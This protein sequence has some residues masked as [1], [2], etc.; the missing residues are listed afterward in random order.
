MRENRER[1]E[2]PSSN[3]RAFW[4][5][6]ETAVERLEQA[7]LRSDEVHLNEI[8]VDFD[9]AIRQRL[10]IELIKLDQ[11]KRWANQ[12]KR[13]VEDYL[14]QCP[15]LKR[16][17]DAIA[18]LL[19]S[20]CE[21]RT[22]NQDPP[23]IEE[24]ESRFPEIARQTDINSWMDQCYDLSDESPGIAIPK[25]LLASIT[26]RQSVESSRGSEQAL[27]RR[28]KLGRY[29]VLSVLGR[30]GM[31]IVYLAVDNELDRKVAIKLLHPWI[32]DP[33]KDQPLLKRDA[34]TAA[35]L[36]HP[37]ILP[38]FD[39][40][41]SDD[42]THF[43]VMEYVDGG[44]LQD[45]AKNH[46]LSFDAIAEIVAQVA[47]ALE[48]VHQA[49]F[50]H[51]DIKPAN[52]LIGVDGRARITDFGL[53]V[54]QAEVGSQEFSGTI[55]Y[56]APEQFGDK[57]QAID[58]RTDI[59][60]LGVVLFELLTGRRPFEAESLDHL[61]DAIQQASPQSPARFDHGV[62]NELNRICLKCLKKDPDERYARAHEM[63]ADLRSWSQQPTQWRKRAAAT[64]ALVVL[65]VGT[66]FAYAFFSTDSVCPW[67][68]RDCKLVLC[69]DSGA[70]VD[71][72][73]AKST[74]DEIIPQLNDKYGKTGELLQL[75]IDL[76][77][78][79][80]NHDSKWLG[81]EVPV[82]INYD[83]PKQEPNPDAG[84]FFNRYN[85]LI[86]PNNDSISFSLRLR[87]A[88]S[89]DGHF[90]VGTVS[91]DQRDHLLVLAQIRGLRN[92]TDDSK[93]DEFLDP[94]RSSSYLEM[95]EFGTPHGVYLDGGDPRHTLLA[96]LVVDTYRLFFK[97]QC[98]L[99]DSGSP[100]SAGN[101]AEFRLPISCAEIYDRPFAIMN[102]FQNEITV[103]QGQLIHYTL[104]DIRSRQDFFG[105]RHNE[106]IAVNRR[107][108]A[109]WSPLYR[110]INARDF[111]NNRKPRDV[112]KWIHNPTVD[113]RREYAKMKTVTEFES[114]P[115]TPTS[116]LYFV[117]NTDNRNSSYIRISGLN[118][119]VHKFEVQLP[120]DGAGQQK[121]NRT[122]I[123]VDERNGTFTG[124]NFNLGLVEAV[125]YDR[126]F[127]QIELGALLNWSMVRPRYRYV[128]LGDVKVGESRSEAKIYR[129]KPFVPDKN[130]DTDKDT[131]QE[132]AQLRPH[133]QDPDEAA[134]LKETT[135]K[136]IA[137]RVWRLPPSPTSLFSWPF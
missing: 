76:S 61:S 24:I 116:V 89:R 106:I 128:T 2:Q 114:M 127:E 122:E 105:K 6:L 37:S 56:M 41:Q 80:I 118:K 123:D 124:K 49:G 7:W 68:K 92:Y 47:D 103:I 136:P 18:E 79:D 34:K 125:L 27:P 15:Q 88:V 115:K 95:S 73:L 23:T 85:T 94:R 29:R 25:P 65:V 110:Q 43:I 121:P 9:D 55:P 120:P 107:K 83:R 16:E 130:N 82:D 13:Y 87:F 60:S 36:T 71:L 31:G 32:F 111:V 78:F 119:P 77:E 108:N 66:L 46:T 63:A 1:V 30:G 134:R 117:A 10:L 75:N 17:H 28:Y 99:D 53:A 39:F 98:L 70:S 62:P 54:S 67:L 57:N 22:M 81:W 96:E 86:G 4:E 109:H 19:R 101:A 133:W 3:G 100:V 8:L 90:Q 40:G 93:E 44:S 52:I 64:L 51:R 97:R 26:T 131:K 126:S 72:D 104:R 45:V 33:D 102:Y 137:P 50:V 69:F 48:T 132:D 129:V 42:G 11:E 59:W 113:E 84:G 135:S 91:P 21:I 74:I 20:E 35:Q 5:A 112:G 14:E 12:S 58:G 38:I